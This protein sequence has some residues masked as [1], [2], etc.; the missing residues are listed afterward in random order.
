MREAGALAG[1]EL[2]AWLWRKG[3]HAEQLAQWRAAALAGL[4]APRPAAAPA[5]Q[6]ARRVKALERE[7]QRKEKALAEAAALL[8]LRKKV[9]ALWAD[10]ADDTDDES[11]T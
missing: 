6:T 10:G 5:A 11:E 3:L 1:D 7:L 8:V 9:A 2:G 4:D